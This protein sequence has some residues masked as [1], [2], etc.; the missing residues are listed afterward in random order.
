MN[1]NISHYEVTGFQN[2][3]YGII[4]FD[5]QFSWK[6]NFFTWLG[7]NIIKI[8]TGSNIEHVGFITKAPKEFIGTQYTDEYGGIQVVQDG[9]Y[10]AEPTQHYNSIVTPLLKRLLK[11]SLN[12]I[13]DDGKSDWSGNIYI[14]LIDDKFC[15]KKRHLDTFKSMLGLTNQQLWNGNPCKYS[16][17]TAML[18]PFPFSKWVRKLFG[19]DKYATPAQFCSTQ[20]TYLTTKSLGL[21]F[22]LT[23]ALGETPRDLSDKLAWN[24]H[25]GIREFLLVYKDGKVIA[26]NEKYITATPIFKNV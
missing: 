13:G 21:D 8:T 7:R 3:T 6:N 24:E 18:S 15:N 1:S 23:H 22:D 12:D 9:Y 25:S 20:G 19:M 11:P 26:R 5:T 16:L 17:P 10:V 4:M 2:V 14:Q